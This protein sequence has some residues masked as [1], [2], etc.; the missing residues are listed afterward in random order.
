MDSSWMIRNDGKVI[1]VKNH[2]FSSLDDMN[3]ILGAIEWLYENTRYERVKTS[4][5]RTFVIY[6]RWNL[7]RGSLF[8]YLKKRSLEKK[9]YFPS[10]TFFASIRDEMEEMDRKLMIPPLEDDL[11]KYLE[12][13]AMQLNQEFIRAGLRRNERGNVQRGQMIIGISSVAYDWYPVISN[14]IRTSGLDIRTLTIVRDALNG[15]MTDTS[16]PRP[17]RDGFYDA[18]PIK[19]M[20]DELKSGCP[21]NH[22]YYL[23]G[24]MHVEKRIMNARLYEGEDLYTISAARGYKTFR[25]RYLKLLSMEEALVKYYKYKAEKLLSEEEKDEGESTVHLE[26]DAEAGDSG[27]SAVPMNGG[28]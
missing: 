22:L 4:I 3:S 24:Y 5:I 28:E 20:L 2:P 10:V 7:P 6:T 26:D 14:F 12:L 8:D 15:V 1:A 16:Y 25:S 9:P 18:V 21:K 11:I 19:E 23:H 17:E 27:D 13:S